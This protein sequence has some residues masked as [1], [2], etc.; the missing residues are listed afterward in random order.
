MTDSVF[1]RRLIFFTWYN[2]STTFLKLLLMLEISFTS[3]FFPPHCFCPIPSPLTHSFI[4]LLSPLTW[5]PEMTVIFLPVHINPVNSVLLPLTQW[6]SG[7]DFLPRRH[8][9]VSRDTLGCHNWQGGG[10]S[11]YAFGIQ[12]V[13]AGDAACH[14]VI[15]RTTPLPYQM[16]VQWPVEYPALVLFKHQLHASFNSLRAKFRCP[17]S[18]FP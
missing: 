10:V 8:L 16:S 1:L 6:F 15:H 9:A 7:G 3:F 13:E 11:K 2:H 4:P 17:S 5:Q 12:Q 18:K 14:P